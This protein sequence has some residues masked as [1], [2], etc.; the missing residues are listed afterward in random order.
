[1]FIEIIIIEVSD[2]TKLRTDSSVR[3]PS[4]SN[5][6]RRTGRETYSGFRSTKYF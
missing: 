4:K 3:I 1:M 2:T 5:V 6:F